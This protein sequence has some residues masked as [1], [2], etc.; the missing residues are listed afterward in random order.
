[1]NLSVAMGPLSSMG[2]PS[3]LTTRPIIAS[4][5][6][7]LMMRAGALDLVAFLD[8]GVVAEQHGADLVFFQVHGEA[9]NAVREL[10]QF[11][12]HD[13]F[14]TV[15]AGDAVAHRHHR[16][17]FIDGDLGF[18][19]FD[20]LADELGNLVCLDLSHMKSSCQ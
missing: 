1:M 8:L 10:E 6:G 18:V 15:D 19:I 14:E 20:L 4:P 7:T 17:D 5:T 3:P 13:L 11:A 2:W 12:G 16:A 9:G